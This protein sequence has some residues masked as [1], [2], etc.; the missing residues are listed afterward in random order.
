MTTVYDL[1]HGQVALL[2]ID[3]Q[4]D[5][6]TPG[7]SAEVPSAGTI[8]PTINRLIDGFRAVDKPV[9]FI[10]HANRADGSDAGRM[11]DF[12][13]G[14]V[15]DAFVEGSAGAEFEP[16]LDYRSGDLVVT[17][18]RYDS[19]L[20]TELD[21]ILRTAGCRAIVI[22]GLMTSFCCET[23]ARA[24]HG[25]DYEVLFV[26]DANEGPD[27]VAAD[28]STI[29]HRTVLASTVAALSAGFAEVVPAHEVLARVGA[30]S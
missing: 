20:G 17:K 13:P 18:R 11:M 4:H 30:S 28:G 23:T 21:A 26:E 14:G 19:F 10:R 3:V 9:I 7:G 2:V 6:F 29:D 8:L 15:V 27:L 25:R 5:Y 1:A 16:S 22:T 12:V 24:G